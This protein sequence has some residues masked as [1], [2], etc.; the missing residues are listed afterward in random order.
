MNTGK[1]D[2]AIHLPHPTDANELNRN[3]RQWW[4][5][6]TIFLVVAI[7]AEAVFAGAML[8]GFGWARSAHLANAG[9]LIIST[10]AAGLAA[11]VTLRR[12]PHGLKFSLVL[13]GLAVVVLLQA[14]VGKSA[15][16]GA[17]LMWLHVPLGVALVG[18]AAQAVASARKLVGE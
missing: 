3:P 12:A 18:F 14:A 5:V 17:N 16:T 4:T 6:I 8:S 13:L 15:S 11:I 2:V 10:I 9:I 7:F 1:Y